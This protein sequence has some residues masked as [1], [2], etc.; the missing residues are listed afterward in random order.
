[1]SSG[2]NCGKRGSD[3]GQDDP[4]TA[5]KVR[6]I[7][8][9]V[10]VSVGQGDTMQEFECYSVILSHASDYFDT[11]FSSQ[12]KEA[13]TKRISFHD[14]D[15]KEWKEVYKF[16]DYDSK[17][18]AT[19]TKS[20]IEMLLP[21]FDLLQM[22][23]QINQCD[24]LLECNVHYRCDKSKEIDE[25]LAIYRTASKYGLAKTVAVCFDQLKWTLSNAVEALNLQILQR[26]A[27]LVTEIG[28]DDDFTKYFWEWSK[29]AVEI[30]DDCNE[31]DKLL[32]SPLFVRLLFSET[33]RKKEESDCKEIEKFLK[34]LPDE[35]YRNIPDRTSDDNATSKLKGLIWKH[36][37][38]FAR[39]N[40]AVPGDFKIHF[41]RIG[42]T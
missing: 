12:M 16:I 34:D 6:S 1:M 21:W 9:D 15:P 27:T 5:K 33:M 4:S 30:S 42:W 7:P 25:N 26:I 37:H 32:R 2:S 22:T 40:V 31:R 18:S 39:L 23:K 20:N 13:T 3:G 38:K 29:E 10:V 11:M 19:I 36:R 14:K 8:P 17:D 24:A 28:N 41:E 35:L